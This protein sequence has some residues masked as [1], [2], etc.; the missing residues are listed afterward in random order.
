MSEGP[1]ALAFLLVQSVRN[2]LRRQL[3]R[4]RTPRYAVALL[5]GLGYLWLVFAPPGA[6][7]APRPGA[8]GGTAI[9]TIGGLGI[10]ITVFLWWL[11]GGVTGALAFQP[12]EVQFLF[13]APLTRRA[14]S[15]YTVARSQIALLFSALL[16]TVLARRWGVT[17][18]M[19]LR[20]VTAW[21][22]FSVLSLH[23]LG[24]ALVQL[25][26]LSPGR[27]AARAGARAVA[28]AGLAAVA[29]GVLPVLARFGE[30]GASGGFQAVGV[31]LST[32]PASWALAPFRLMM[33]PLFAPSVAGWVAAFGW[34]AAVA[35]TQLLWVVA[36]SGVPF[37]E[38]AATASADLARRMSA[39]RE[40]RGGGAAVIRSKKPVRSRL[41]LAPTGWPAA[42]LVWKNTL[43]LVRTGLLRTA[44]I[45]L[46]IC[47][48]AS[49]IVASNAGDENAVAMAMPWLTIAIMTFVL[50]PRVVRNDLRQD[51]LSLA[52]LKTYPLPGAVLVLAEMLSPTMVLTGFQLGMVAVAWF[53]L[54]G[55]TRQ[56][57][58]GGSGAAAAAVV[59]PVAVLVLNG[60]NVAVQNGF[61]LLFPSWVR[62]GPDSGGIEAIGQNMLVTIGSLVALVLTLLLPVVAGAVAR[63][64][65]GPPAA[66]SFAAAGAAGSVVLALELAGLLMLLGKAFD[67]IEPAAL[68]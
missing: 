31:A 53:S 3:S 7:R 60:A 66:L 40:R 23:R 10:A 17:I 38:A 39:F 16:W 58:G 19:P 62:L 11:R 47:V 42:A 6:G 54:P 21:G 68:S 65:T 22:F 36:M 29:F 45:F 43:A 61:A 37:E 1:G 14:L 4:V 44:I 56:S 48:I 28:A 5:F 18:P 12:A 26:P 9:T 63:V 67:R 2:R 35:A 25:E 59:L 13:P 50:G 33:A 27:R 49:R 8:S 30:L 64:L 32:P 55:V 24:A 52:Q 57:L 46:A 34:V 41:P 20:F 51:L 15:L